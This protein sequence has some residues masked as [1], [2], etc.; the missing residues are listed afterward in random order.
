MGWCLPTPTPTLTPTRTPH[1]LSRIMLWGHSWLQVGTLHF[2]A[3][4]VASGQL[5]DTALA[6][7]TGGY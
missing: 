7:R 2:M 5:L 1:N 4:E 6:D 3:P